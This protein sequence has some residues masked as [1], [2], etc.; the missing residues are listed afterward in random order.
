M[1]DVFHNGAH[2]FRVG[3]RRNRRKKSVRSNSRIITGESRALQLHKHHAIERA[4]LRQSPANLVRT[5]RR[6]RLLQIARQVRL[7]PL[8][9][10][11]TLI[12]SFDLLSP[13]SVQ[14]WH[15]VFV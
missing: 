13:H 9:Q 15:L 4:T 14:P 2:H 5:R 7:F 8:P 12:H 3:S 6:R 1:P 10:V 11:D